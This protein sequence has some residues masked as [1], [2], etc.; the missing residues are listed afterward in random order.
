[1]SLSSA[2][3]ISAISSFTLL[4]PGGEMVKQTSVSALEVANHRIE[5]GVEIPRVNY[6]RADDGV[7][8]YPAGEQM[9]NPTNPF[10]AP[11]QAPNQNEQQSLQDNIMP[12][13][14]LSEPIENSIK[15]IE[16]SQ[17]I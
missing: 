7:R 6:G 11:I 3:V 15:P 9:V 2:V 17:G 12:E 4:A 5:Q 1:M 10:L 13:C 8:I 14:H 16:D